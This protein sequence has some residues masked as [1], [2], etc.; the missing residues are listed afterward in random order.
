MA[1]INFKVK[2][3]I[4]SEPKYFFVCTLFILPPLPMITLVMF[5]TH[6]QPLVKYHTVY[7]ASNFSIITDFKP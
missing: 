7:H 1:L 5:P 6:F 3:K 4:F 2:F